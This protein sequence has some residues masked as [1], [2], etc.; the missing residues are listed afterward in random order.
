M[1]LSENDCELLLKQAISAAYQAGDI[2]HQYSRQAAHKTLSIQ[3]KIGGDSQASQV[4]TEVDYLCQ[5]AILNILLPTCKTWNLALLT[6]EYEDDKKRLEK[7]YF[8]CIDPLDGTL[9][10]IESSAGYAVSIALVSR[11]GIPILGVVYDPVKQTLYYACKDSG[12]F[13]NNTSWQLMS[14]KKPLTI[15]TDRS[16]LQYDYYQNIMAQ[17]DAIASELGFSGLHTIHFGGAV[18]NAC[19]VLENAPACYFKFPKKQDGGGSLWDYAATACLF[20][21]IGAVV[22]DINANPLELNRVDS[23]FMNHKGIVYASHTNIAE[24]IRK[25]NPFKTQI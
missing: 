5:E 9:P 16:F 15:I 6:E 8:W 20:N 19:W 13:R 18:M 4:V 25:I 1:L 2:I 10:F 17:L 3:N 12:A 22:S 24:Q 7:D 11:S 23:C 21:E 14:E